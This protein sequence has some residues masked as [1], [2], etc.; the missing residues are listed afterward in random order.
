MAIKYYRVRALVG[1]L[2]LVLGCAHFEAVL[3]AE[4]SPPVVQG[5]DTSAKSIELRSFDQSK[6]ASHWA[7]SVE[8]IALKRSNNSVSQPLVSTLPGSSTFAQTENTPASE[9][10][11]SNQFQQGRAVGPKFT[12]DYIGDSGYGFQLSYFNVQNLN[13]SNTVGPSDSSNWYIMRA[14]GFWQTQDFAYQG[15]TWGSTTSLYSTEANAKLKA[16]DSFTLLAGLRWIQLKDS[17]VGS[18]SPADQ[19]VPLWKT[20]GCPPGVFGI[21]DIT[22]SQ[23]TQA[24]A[25][26]V[27]ISGYP[28]FWSTNTRNNLLGLQLGAQGV[29]FEI[30][31]LSIG[32][33]LK[34][35]VFNNQATQSNN[36]S[37]T[38]IIYSSSVTSNQVAYSGEGIFQLKYLIADGLAIKMG[39]Q[40]LWLDRVALAPGQIPY[41]LSGSDPTSVTARG[42][43]TGSNILFQGGTVG[44]EYLF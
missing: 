30:G 24:C 14:P 29:F 40:L 11:N 2:C 21:G 25:S 43:N 28:P 35:G 32:G 10:F 13:A 12:L 34:A 5:A 19:N 27:G 4:P 16:S 8:A 17:L 31:R 39:Y 1:A 26:G 3:S 44:M 38:K 36:V 7:L 15:M 20:G 37:I 18:L 6:S 23:T 22:L 9:I 41:V 42:V 33:S